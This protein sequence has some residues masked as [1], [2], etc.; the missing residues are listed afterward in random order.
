MPG[1]A[2]V[3][4][5]PRGKSLTT[6]FPSPFYKPKTKH[7]GRAAPTDWL[8]AGEILVRPLRINGSGV[9]SFGAP[10]GSTVRPAGSYMIRGSGILSWRRRALLKVP[11]GRTVLSGRCHQRF[12]AR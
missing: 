8:H 4:G 3:H 2:L 10:P 11:P 5:L 9:V 7:P 1:Q 12:T 6:F